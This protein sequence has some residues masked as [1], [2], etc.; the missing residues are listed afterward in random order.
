MGRSFRRTLAAMC[1]GGGVLVVAALPAGADV[2]DPPGACQASGVWENE[3]ETRDSADYARDAVVVIPQE[4][5]VAWEGG[6]GDAAPGETG[7][8]RDIQ[9]EVE[10]VIS[11]VPVPI[12]DWDGPSELYGNSDEYEYEVPDYLVNVELKLQGSHS[13]GG[14]QVC[15]GSVYVVVEG[16]IFDNP[17][18]IVAMIGL[19]LMILLLFYAGSVKKGVV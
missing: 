15:E 2:I 17:L 6:V 3:G 19:L 18:A 13:E 14:S 1:V 9:G 16:G 7:P 4:D 10:V 11:G 12:D 5:T 8:E